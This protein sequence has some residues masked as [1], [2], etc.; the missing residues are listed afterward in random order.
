MIV[1]HSRLDPLFLVPAYRHSPILLAYLPNLHGLVPD[2]NPDHPPFSF[3]VP[4]HDVLKPVDPCLALPH[5]Y[6]I[7][8]EIW[9]AIWT[10]LRESCLFP[11][12]CPPSCP[13]WET[14]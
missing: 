12:L 8:A 11:F 1:V 13:I 6:Y 3:P 5:S 10:A 4:C 7:C 14:L 9:I 2:D